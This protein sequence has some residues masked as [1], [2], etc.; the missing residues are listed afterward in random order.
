MRVLVCGATGC[1]GSAVT[2]AL[3]ARG[4]LVVVAARGVADGPRGLALDFMSP[5]TPASWATTLTERGIE[6]VVNCVGILVPTRRQRFERVHSAGPIEL[7]RGAALAGVRRVVQVSALGVGEDTESLAMPYLHS[8]LLADEALAALPMDWAV[9]RPSLVYGPGSQSARAVRHPGEPA[10]DRPA[11]A[12][13]SKRCSQSMCMNWPRWWPACSNSRAP[14]RAVLPLGGG[15]QLTYRQMLA[16]YRQAQG[17]GEAWWQPVPM[18]L[19]MLGAWLAEHLPQQVYSRDTMRLLA[20]GQVPVGNATAE[21]LGRPPTGMAQGLAVSPPRAAIDLAVSLSPVVALALRSA[22]AFMWI[23]TA[24]VSLVWQQASGVMDLLARCGFE[25]AWGHGALLASCAL[26]ISL[27]LM[28]LARPTAAVYAVQLTA[29]LGYTLT[30]AIHM[31][32]LTIDHCGPL[33]KNL[34]ILVAA[35]LLWLDHAGRPATP[36]PAPGRSTGE[37]RRP[38]ATTRPC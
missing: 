13:G 10:R 2:R 36:A 38:G 24:L 9:L 35:G 8:K 15:E 6:C 23:Y 12:G 33:V 30:A 18:P 31:P 3:R 26:N 4:H 37:R 19:M 20:R 22:L 14:V 17:L 7:F 11:R 21:V 28:T 16:R 34:P 29:I 27:G 1:I 5:R 25:G 32:E